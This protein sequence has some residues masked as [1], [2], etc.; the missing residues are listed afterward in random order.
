MAF[1]NYLF[2]GDKDEKLKQIK[3]I[4]NH[5]QKKT[6]NPQLDDLIRK[7]L[8]EDPEKRLTWDQYFK[9]PFIRQK[10]NVRNYYEVEKTNIGKS[11]FALIYKW[12]Q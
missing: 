12:R 5:L 11:R 6:D 3:N 8:V 1:H 9:H 2:D 10:E 7:L 4:N